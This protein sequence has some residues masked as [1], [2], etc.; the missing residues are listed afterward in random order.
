MEFR[1]VNYTGV[2][3]SMNPADYVVGKKVMIPRPEVTAAEIANARRREFE[4]GRSSGTDEAPWTIKTDGG[5]GF[6]ADP[7]R[8]SAVTQPN[9]W[10]IW[11]LKSG[12]GWAHPVHIHFEEGRILT[13]DGAPPP[14]WEQLARKDVFNIGDGPG[15]SSEVEVLIRFREFLGTYMEHCHNTQHEDHAM[16][17]RWDSRKPGQTIAIPTPISEWEGV[18]YEPSF[19]LKKDED[20]EDRTSGAAD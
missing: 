12:G 9:Q 18:Y 1:V 6:G 8:V 19:G 7:H 14:Q 17:L 10:E 4:F 16:L 5:Q 15:A 2:D 11:S 13:R 20:G 3:R